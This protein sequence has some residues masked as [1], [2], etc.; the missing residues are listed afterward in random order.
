MIVDLSASLS[1]IIVAQHIP[2]H[3]FCAIPTNSL[4]ILTIF[5]DSKTTSLMEVS[6]QPAIHTPITLPTLQRKTILTLGASTDPI[7]IIQA[8]V[9]SIDV[10]FHASSEYLI[11]VFIANRRTRVVV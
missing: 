10:E 8:R 5:N 2:I 11:D 3:A 1:L 4:E 7:I 9:S 6:V